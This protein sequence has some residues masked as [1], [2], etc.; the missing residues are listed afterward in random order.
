M[1]QIPLAPAGNPREVEVSVELP[2]RQD[3]RGGTLRVVEYLLVGGAQ[4]GSG[5]AGFTGAG[6]AV[7]PGESATGDLDPDTA[8]AWLSG[9][10]CSARWVFFSFST[11]RNIANRRS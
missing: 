4:G 1:D 5:G 10:V 9:S 2:D 3:D 6:V 7:V 8:S 11:L